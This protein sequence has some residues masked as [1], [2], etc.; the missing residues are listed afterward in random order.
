MS[1][2]ACS[3]EIAREGGHRAQHWHGV[4]SGR[5]VWCG[6]SRIACGTTHIFPTGL[7][8]DRDDLF[9]RLDGTVGL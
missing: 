1:S 2:A 7:F 6:F 5:N 4:R 8:S 9:L 3:I